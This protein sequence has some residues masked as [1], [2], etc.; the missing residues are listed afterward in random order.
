MPERSAEPNEAG[1]R[2]GVEADGERGR[3]D[4]FYDVGILRRRE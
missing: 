1:G 4:G 3:L 2:G